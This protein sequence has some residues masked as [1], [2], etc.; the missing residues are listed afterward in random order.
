MFA[1]QKHIQLAKRGYSRIEYDN[2]AEDF[3]SRAVIQLDM[4]IDT[5]C[6]FLEE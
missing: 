1:A 2:S 6:I 3:C 5:W 4:S